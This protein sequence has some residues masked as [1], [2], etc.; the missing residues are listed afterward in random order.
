QRRAGSEPRYLLRSGVGASLQRHDPLADSAFL[1]I[2]DLDGAPP[3][4]RIARAIA[5]TR[6][7]VVETFRDQITRAQ[8]VEWDDDARA[9][10]AWQ[11]TQLGAIVLQEHAS[12]SPNAEQIR[13]VFAH[14]IAR[15]GVDS[16]PWSDAAAALRERMAFLHAHDA[17]W[18]DVGA[19]ALT[20]GIE[21][22]LTAS[23]GG[24]RKWEDLA[25]VDLG[26][27]LR[28]LLT[29]E[30]RAALDQLAPTHLD[31]PSGSRI[32]INY[33]TPTSPVLA[34]KLQEVFGWSTTPTLLNGRVAITLH[35]LSPAQRPVQVTRDLAGFWKTSYFEVRKDLRGRY[36]R[37]PW[38]ED[39]LNAPPTRRAK[40]RGT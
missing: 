36:P 3:E 4:Y 38:P 11:R 13:E 22:W 5:L 37:H 9:V 18:P 31:V 32:A 33:E 30:Q 23:I 14:Q 28:G 35:L 27:S 16:L 17:A 24:I 34:V 10:R 39:P 6:E 20:N 25:R 8:I 15:V 29:W 19:E 40:P 1:A 12:A 2:A 7:Q 21:N 26:E